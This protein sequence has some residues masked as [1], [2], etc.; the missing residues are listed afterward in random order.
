M[1][2]NTE[3]KLE[4]SIVFRFHEVRSHN[5]YVLNNV[6]CRCVQIVQS[7]VNV[8]IQIQKMYVVFLRFSQILYVT[9]VTITVTKLY[10]C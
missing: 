1:F 5:I 7:E 6:A 10:P 8:N 3:T 9:T 4:V 2:Y